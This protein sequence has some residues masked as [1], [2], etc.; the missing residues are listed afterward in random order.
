MPIKKN[1]SFTIAKTGFRKIQKIA[2]AQNNT[3]AKISC[4]TVCLEFKLDLL[5][6]FF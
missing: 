5:P 2:H 1:Q 6:R 3:P 4:H